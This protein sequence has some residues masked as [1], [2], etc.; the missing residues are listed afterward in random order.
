[1]TYSI[2][3]TGAPPAAVATTTV[4]VQGT[5]TGTA[6]SGSHGGGGALDLWALVLLSLPMG[7]R[8]AR[9]RARP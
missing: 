6:G 7:L 1:V 2:T 3:C 5:A 8:F 4:V 9:E